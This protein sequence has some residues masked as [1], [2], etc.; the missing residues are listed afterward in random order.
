MEET[1][2]ISLGGSLI[3][4]EELDVEF[5]KGF[6]ELILSHVAQGKK[7]VIITGG[8][9]IARKYQGAAKELGNPSNDD[10]DWLGIASLRLNAELVRVMFGEYA[11]EEVIS[12]LSSDFSFNKPIVIGSADEPGQSSDT[13]AVLG[14]NTVGAKKIINLSNAD[15]VYDSDP[16]TNPNAKKLENISWA[17]YRAII[18]KEWNP[19][20]N[21][22]FDPI[23][24][25]MA[26]KAGIQV[27][28][29][30]GKPMDNL[31]NCLA[32]EKFVGTIIA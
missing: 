21:S 15:H 4:P 8:G 20:L 13:D 27:M 1:I 7:F 24:S 29:M 11:H 19:G 30:N 3:I 23:A 31:K 5:L 32:G 17:D 28:I 12:H 10:L 14:A 9:R 6:K 16:R 2:I 25:E 26:E 18:P 22:P